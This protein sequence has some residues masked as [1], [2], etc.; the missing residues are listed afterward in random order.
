MSKEFTGLGA[1]LAIIKYINTQTEPK[2]GQEIYE[3]LVKGGYTTKQKDAHISVL[4]E[5]QSLQAEGLLK[6]TPKKAPRRHAKWFRV[7][8]RGGIHSPI[9]TRIDAMRFIPSYLAFQ[10]EPKLKREIFR[11]LQLQGF[12]PHVLDPLQLVS[13]YLCRLRKDGK[14]EKV[15]KPKEQTRWRIAN[16]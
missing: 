6:R 3:A 8:K 10:S 11:A 15:K 16:G 2:T 14:I 12:D 7:K 13:T 5:L 9:L 1:K 4:Q